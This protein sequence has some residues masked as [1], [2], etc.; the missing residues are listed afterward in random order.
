LDVNPQKKTDDPGFAACSESTCHQTAV[1][2]ASAAGQ[3]V[4]DIN[5]PLGLLLNHSYSASEHKQGSLKGVDS[6]VM[7]ELDKIKQNAKLKL[8]MLPVVICALVRDPVRFFF[9]CIVLFE[10]LY[11]AYIQ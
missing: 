3:Y 11:N 6:F 5:M 4:S 10:S 7:A 1:E 9:T 8:T 2:V